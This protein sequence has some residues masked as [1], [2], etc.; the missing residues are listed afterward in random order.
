[1]TVE[2]INPAT[3]QVTYRHELLDAQGIEQRLQ[4]AADAFPGWAARSLAERGAILKQV[5][6]QLRER[7]VRDV[8]VTVLEVRDLAVA[9]A[10]ETVGGLREPHLDAA[11]R[12]LEGADAL[13]VA[14]PVFRGSYAGV[15]KVVLDLLEPGSLRGVPTAL[16]ATSGTVRHT[17]VTEHAMRPLLSYLGAL[18]LPTTIV[19]TP[20]DL[21]LGSRPVPELAARVTRS[22]NELADAVVRD[23]SAG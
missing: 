14:S 11:L 7:G 4:A 8:E 18:T 17:L 6:A 21:V 22:A 2:I 13:V 9:A 20:N 10:A 1:M 15:F 12:S 5:A 3:G 16:A 23:R 19:A